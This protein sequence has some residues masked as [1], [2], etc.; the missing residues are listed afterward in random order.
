MNVL[1]E[2]E[3]KAIILKGQGNVFFS[4]GNYANAISCYNQAIEIDIKFKEAWLNKALCHEKLNQRQEALEALTQ[5]III[6]PL[7]AKAIYNKANILISMQHYEL[8]IETIDCYLAQDGKAEEIISLRKD[9]SHKEVMRLGGK[10]SPLGEKA[11]LTLPKQEI[12][13]SKQPSKQKS[14]T[15]KMSLPQQFTA[16]IKSGNFAAVQAIIEAGVSVNA[17]LTTGEFPQYLS[18]KMGESPNPF[19]IEGLLSFQQAQ[20]KFGESPLYLAASLGKLEIVDFLLRH[21]AEVN[22]RENYGLTPLMVSISKGYIQVALRL[23]AE[24]N[25]MV[26]LAVQ[27]GSTAL[28]FACEKGLKTVVEVIITK[29]ADIK[30]ADKDGET[31]LIIAATHNQ[32][33]IIKL[34]LEAGASPNQCKPNGVSPLF[35]AAQGD[36]LEG[37]KRLVFFGA[38]LERIRRSDRI[39]AL[40][41]AACNGCMDTVFYLLACGANPAVTCIDHRSALDYAKGNNHLALYTHL[42]NYQK[43]YSICSAENKK[44]MDLFKKGDYQSALTIFESLSKQ[45]IVLYHKIT[46]ID[47]AT[48][49]YN[50]A[51]CHIGLG[52][53][54]DAT[55]YLKK[56]YGVFLELFGE[57]NILT[58]QAKLECDNSL[59]KC[60]SRDRLAIE[61]NTRID[62]KATEK[63]VF[64][65][66]E[67]I[68]P[69]ILFSSSEALP[70]NNYQPGFFSDKVSDPQDIFSAIVQ[71]DFNKLRWFIQNGSN[72]NAHATGGGKT[73]L[74]LAVQTHQ[75]EMVDLL[76]EAKA[77]VNATTKTQTAPLH[78]AAQ[79]G[80]SVI[81]NKLL[82]AEAKID[83]V[84]DVGCTPLH[85]AAANGHQ[86]AV[87]TLVTRGANT[88]LKDYRFDLT[89][90]QLAGIYKKHNITAIL[91]PELINDLIY[92]P[93]IEFIKTAFKN[94]YNQSVIWKIYHSQN[95]IHAK[96]NMNFTLE[97]DAKLYVEK[98]H[99]IG[100]T[101]AFTKQTEKGWELIVPNLN[102]VLSNCRI[103][104]KYSE[105]VQKSF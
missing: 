95:N 91:K 47:L 24:P 30:Q 26:N 81:I 14:S 72:V 21:N 41:I 10:N 74:H 55:K 61:I 82:D 28:S 17:L 85:E 67:E 73:P 60:L 94:K 99:F 49:F 104:Q 20:P 34:L 23:L 27:D 2:V 32:S 25:I 5:G 92:K 9:C 46:S 105:S 18:H 63:S 84:S 33:E 76:I 57:T 36:Q 16:A 22:K 68:S 43:K 96:A 6:D 78:V 101:K 98:L 86:N 39:N 53:I 52:Q 1:S 62:M 29:G 69:S 50:I 48:C 15:S 97:K 103:G 79:N 54:E 12:K 40:L 75:E 90:Y 70:K 44:G 11:I 64:Q 45:Y 71:K 83:I 58:V 51:E 42:V 8:A 88:E 87:I 37:V 65:L 19:N 100:L 89:P 35:L 13:P 7:Y 56:Y 66:P 93:A 77:D 102:E 3:N 59:K 38:D 31:P 4:Q 80:N